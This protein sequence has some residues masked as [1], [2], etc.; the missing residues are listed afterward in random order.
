MS[1]A[2]KPTPKIDGINTKQMRIINKDMIFGQY[3][4]IP[5]QMARQTVHFQ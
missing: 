3:S 2:T 1:I 5:D 4:R